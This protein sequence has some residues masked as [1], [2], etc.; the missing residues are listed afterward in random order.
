MIIN[1]HG[2]RVVQD[3]RGALQLVQ[4]ADTGQMFFCRA[5]VVVDFDDTT[6][7]AA[8]ALPRSIVD[9]DLR[10]RTARTVWRPGPVRCFGTGGTLRIHP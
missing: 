5:S 7:A 3:P 1:Q 4:C 9:G 8:T 6:T 10:P 2:Q